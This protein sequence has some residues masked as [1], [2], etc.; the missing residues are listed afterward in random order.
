MIVG[1]YCVSHG[2]V[3]GRATQHAAAC[4]KRRTSMITH[5]LRTAALAAHLSSKDPVRAACTDQR[6]DVIVHACAQAN[7]ITYSALISACS[8]CG[9][10][11][12]AEKHFEDML[13]ASEDDP[14]C[15]PN[16][17]T[18]SSLIT[19]CVRGGHLERA[20]VW[21]G[22]MRD[23]NVDADFIIYR[24]VPPNL[25]PAIC[26]SGAFFLGRSSTLQRERKCMVCPFAG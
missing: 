20:L 6:A 15:A 25:N 16:T 22:K 1:S 4:L 5:P 24:Y 21:Y 23:N 18:Y 10:W 7:V 17:I 11:Q 14:D 13:T 2:A 12:E 9:R 19:A 8:S 3:P 26:C